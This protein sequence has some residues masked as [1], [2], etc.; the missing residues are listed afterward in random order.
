MRNLISA[1]TLRLFKNRLFYGLLS[2]AFLF[3]I[4]LQMYIY[5]GSRYVDMEPNMMDGFFA[6]GAIIG[7]FAAVFVSLFV[8]TE[9]SDGTIRNKIIHGKRR[10]HIYLS[11]LILCS[12]A[13][14]LIYAAYYAGSLL[15]GLIFCNHFTVDASSVAV[16]ALVLYVS[17]CAYTA[18]FLAIAMNCSK[19]SAAAVVSL[20]L[21]VALFFVAAAVTSALSEPE[22]YDECIYMD[23]NGELQKDIAQPNP[24]YLRGTKRQ[25]FAALN[26]INP[27]G[28]C[29][30]ISGMIENE[31]TADTTDF[32]LYAAG[33]IVLCTSVGLVVFKK[34][35][36]S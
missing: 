11:K 9:Y 23:E 22:Y 5:F 33:L 29:M 31:E 12:L 8:G 32:L 18:L 25:I 2:A 21:T 16:T 30:Q 10:G 4:G 35:D 14:L 26:D 19:K 34:K 28:Q 1:E 6:I 27:T 20:L 7:F 3:G 13:L 36:I 17:S 15:F 24:N